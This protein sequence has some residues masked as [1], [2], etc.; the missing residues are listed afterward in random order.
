MAAGFAA[1]P[2]EW[3]WGCHCDA[4]GRADSPLSCQVPCAAAVLQVVVGPAGFNQRVPADDESTGAL[5]TLL[6]SG[7]PV[8]RLLLGALFPGRRCQG[9]FDVA[10]MALPAAG[11]LPDTTESFPTWP[12]RVSPVSGESPGPT[13]HA[14]MRHPRSPDVRQHSMSARC[15][16]SSGSADSRRPV[17]TAEGGRIAAMGLL[18]G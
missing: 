16:T 3:L 4:G 9:A 2:A 10:A 12:T 7:G 13:R 6:I 1:S 18:A 14:G 15:S 8:G 5:T 17:H 11:E